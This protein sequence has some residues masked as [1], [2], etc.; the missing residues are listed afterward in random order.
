MATAKYITGKVTH[1]DGS[2]AGGALVSLKISQPALVTGSEEVVDSAIHATAAGDGTYTVQAYSGADLTPGG[3]YY[4]Y[5]SRAGDG[6]S[7]SIPVVLVPTGADV[8][9]HDG[10]IGNPYLM[11]Q[12]VGTIPAL[13]PGPAHVGSLTVDGA[14]IF[15]SGPVTI[16][17]TLGVTGLASFSGGLTVS[18][19]PVT[20][21]V[22]S[23]ADEALSENV[24]LL[25]EANVF[26]AAQTFSG[27][28]DSAAAVRIAGGKPW[29]DPTHPSFAGGAVGNGTDGTAA[30]AAWATA[31]G[32]GGVGFVPYPA[33]FY[34]IAATVLFNAI[35]NLSILG[36]SSTIKAKA[37]S[38]WGG[39]AGRYM[40]EFQDCIGVRIDGL[41]FDAD[42]ANQTGTAWWLSVGVVSS[43]VDGRSTTVKTTDIAVTHC[44]FLNT[45]S[46]GLAFR[47]ARRVL[48]EECR[49]L[50]SYAVAVTCDLLNFTRCDDWVASDC[51]CDGAPNL[52]AQGGACVSGSPGNWFAA[53]F[54]MAINFCQV[55]NYIQRARFVAPAA[56]LAASTA[57]ISY[58]ALADPTTA[59]V[60]ADAGA[61]AL[62][63]GTYQLTYTY[64]NLVGETKAS[65][66]STGLVLGASHQIAVSSITAIPNGVF[67]VKV[68]ITAP[69]G[70]AGFALQVPVVANATG[71]FNVN[72][73]GNAVASPGTNTTAAAETD[74]AGAAYMS[75]DFYFLCSAPGSGTGSGI[76]PSN[77]IIA[78][79]VD[80]T[81]HTLTVQR[82]DGS[83][84]SIAQAW[85]GQTVYLYSIATRLFSNNCVIDGCTLK[86]GQGGH[87]LLACKNFR[88]S[89][90][91]SYNQ[92]DIGLDVEHCIAGSISDN[93]VDAGPFP[94]YT[95]YTG[96]ASL[97]FQRSV[98]IADNSLYQTGIRIYTGFALS[99]DMAIE[100][101]TVR[102][103]D[104]SVTP[105]SQNWDE[106]WEGVVIQGNILNGGNS[107]GSQ[108]GIGGAVAKYAVGLNVG[109]NAN[110]GTDLGGY[111]RDLVI[112]NNRITNYV[113]QAILMY[114]IDGVLIQ[115][116][117][118]S[119]IGYDAI[120]EDNSIL[121]DCK[122]VVVCYNTVSNVGYRWYGG[123]Y[124]YAT[125]VAKT[126]A[127]RIFDNIWKNTDPALDG[128][129]A[130]YAP[131]RVAA[132][133]RGRP[134]LLVGAA[135]LKEVGGFLA[136]ATDATMD[137]SGHW[138]AVAQV[139][140]KQSPAFNAAPTPDPTL[141][142]IYEMA[143]L[144]GAVNVGNPVNSKQGQRMRM[145]WREDG[146]GGR[147]VA[148]TGSNWRS[149]GI[150]AQTTTLN[151]YTIDDAECIDGTIWRV[152]R[153]VT[154]QTV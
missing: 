86:N 84:S 88:S 151:T 64:L 96:I 145:Y 81:N 80:Q 5:Q 149:V 103:G 90:N 121:G 23:I 48:V 123:M 57:V 32:G 49:F 85:A 75:N 99:A 66:A 47:L 3:T 107:E 22:A 11:S 97:F 105:Q 51:Y 52:Q 25:N 124:F 74:S 89:N 142:E 65:S 77:Q 129:Q 92:G 34:L 41:I 110:M 144:T 53:D 140:N 104:L 112:A 95:G 29:Y 35:T 21:P 136:V 101:N 122:R 114:G 134:D 61:G 60:T 14:A 127:P 70:Q 10:S 4:K 37:Q 137:S 143:A 54:A 120:N 6:G 125:A 16:G 36:T 126:E 83:E 148:Y 50:A 76:I 109:R 24:A 146:T 150:A 27:G 78:T 9:G 19:G 26:S 132:A 55:L 28:L 100:G 139:H 20:L 30:F 59:P 141:G 128:T 39:A 147:A 18:A 67:A 46:Y 1:A 2:P 135:W 116:N 94:G 102:G 93:T 118:F 17:G 153:L 63:A 56:A 44:T 111:V 108:A 130:W 68:Y 42:G 87:F 133:P 7:Q 45:R 91:Y 98:V 73:V 12:L 15:S 58:G 154:G 152:V 71:A 131:A 106:L 43:V 117:S 119:N 69:G 62:P 8:N 31:L 40:L 138:S 79:A 33:T 113:Q 115:G 72:N 82:M 38:T 13:I